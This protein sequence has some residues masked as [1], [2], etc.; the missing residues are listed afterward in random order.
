MTRIEIS[1]LLERKGTACVSG[2]DS[3][4]PRQSWCYDERGLY[5]M[6]ETVD[7]PKPA[8]WLTLTMGVEVLRPNVQRNTS[9][10]SFGWLSLQ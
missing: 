3:R 7:I 2:A 9:N 10:R 8:A 5:N 6:Y 4:Q 1:P